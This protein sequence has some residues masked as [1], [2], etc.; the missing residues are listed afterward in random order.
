MLTLPLFL[1]TFLTYGAES[2]CEKL[3]GWR[4]KPP[5]IMQGDDGRVVGVHADIVREALGRLG[6]RAKFLNRPWARAMLQIQDGE[7][8]I[9]AGVGKSSE[10]ETFAWFSQPTNK[11]LNY[12]YLSRNADGR[13]HFKRLSDMLG[14]DFRLSVAT[15]ADYGGEFTALLKDS[16]FPRNL[17]PYATHASAWKMLAL[18]RADGFI[19][20]QL[21]GQYEIEALHLQSDIIKTEIIV[22]PDDFDYLAISK[23][24]NGKSFA[25]SLNRQIS[26]LMADGTYTRI[27]ERY[28]ACTIALANQSCRKQGRN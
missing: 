12:L 28:R 20:D 5:Y 3:V 7:L 26:A 9:M 15:N 19:S 6:C 21:T 1:A 22:N 27:L 24:H 11:A 18:D 4:E 10:R 14:T 23:K 2:P 25:D 17:H 13:F 16:Q 8:D